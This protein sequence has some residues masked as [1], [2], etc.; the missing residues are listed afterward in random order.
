MRPWPGKKQRL[1]AML[2]LKPNMYNQPE[3]SE[4]S[5]VCLHQ[6]KLDLVAGS[7]FAWRKV[8]NN[9]LMRH[10]IA[11]EKLSQNIPLIEFR[12]EGCF[13]SCTFQG[14]GTTLF[15]GELAKLQKA[16]KKRASSLTVYPAPEASSQTYTT[17]PYTGRSRSFRKGGSSYRRK[18]L[19]MLQGFIRKY[20]R[21]AKHLEDG[22]Q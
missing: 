13:T 16:Y 12:S 20:S 17:K 18:Y 11:L 21:C 5:K 10:S 22:V 3:I 6:L 4:E 2:C 15:E 14:Y 8:H 1:L 19:R 7:N 9:M